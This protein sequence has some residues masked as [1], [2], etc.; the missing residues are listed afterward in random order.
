MR[1]DVGVVSGKALD[2]VGIHG[3]FA[4][5]LER[6]ALHL[7]HLRQPLPAR[8]LAGSCMKTTPHCQHLIFTG[9]WVLTYSTSELS[10]FSMCP[11]YAQASI[12]TLVAFFNL[13]DFGKQD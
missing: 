8:W 9:V 3:L 7:P 1:L 6:L 13:G 2:A 5:P 10:N 12:F 11:R 4:N